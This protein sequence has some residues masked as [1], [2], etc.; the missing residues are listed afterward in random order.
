[1]KVSVHMLAYNHEPFIA[2]AIESVLM[3]KVNFDFELVI[4]EDCSTDNTRAIVKAYQQRYPDT[5][6]LFLREQNMGAIQND[7]AL[8][9]AC[10]GQYIAWLEGDDYW[11]TTDKLQKQVDFLDDHPEFSACFG[12]AQ[13]IYEDGSQPTYISRS[14]QPVW[15]LEELFEGMPMQCA[16]TMFRNGLITTFPDWYYSDAIGDWEI[17]L[18]LAQQGPIAYMDEVMS[19][20]RKHSGGIFTSATRIKQ[21]TARLVM[22]EH[23]NTHFR[24]QYNKTIR[25][26]SAQQKYRLALEYAKIGD[27][28]NAQRCFLSSI[29]FSLVSR[30]VRLRDMLL[31]AFK[32]FGSHFRPAVWLA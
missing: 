19:V 22:Y 31:T 11:I 25:A 26:I 1:M 6:R 8:Y 23:M 28:P 21:L 10:R 3:Q 14:T 9:F 15:H 24:Y 29:P 30:R 32:L 18:F 16:A 5:I 20:Y 13:V 2:Q 12:G 4:G 7:V 27:F 17:I